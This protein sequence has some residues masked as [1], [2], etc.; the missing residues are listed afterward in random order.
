M[1]KTV[2]Y[3]ILF[4]A[5]I[6]IATVGRFA[7]YRMLVAHSKWLPEKAMKAAN[8]FSGVTVFVGLAAIAGNAMLS[9]H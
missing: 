9:G 1:E 4:G 5:V 6:V 8:M 7:V 3:S 2:W